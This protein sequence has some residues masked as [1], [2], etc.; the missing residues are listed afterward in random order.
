MTVSRY[1]LHKASG[2][3]LQQDQA[4]YNLSFSCIAYL[5]TTSCLMDPS[6]SES[7]SR[8]RIVK[9]YHGLHLYANKFWFAHLLKYLNSRGRHDILVPAQLREQL[10]NLRRFRKESQSPEFH[11][12]IRAIGPLQSIE[13]R[14]ATLD[15][16]PDTKSLV[17][18]ILAYRQI[19]AQ[20]THTQKSSEGER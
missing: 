3:F 10:S 13:N 5:S 17:H 18:N 16:L 12:Q 9:G 1:I 2:P 15:D 19:L 6:I 4:H 14:T 20:E 11:A 8:L 7:Q